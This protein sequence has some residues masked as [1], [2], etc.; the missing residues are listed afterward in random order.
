MTGRGDA[1]DFR[2]RLL[3]AC[4]YYDAPENYPARAK[5]LPLAKY[6]GAPAEALLACLKAGP[7]VGVAPGPQPIAYRLPG[8]ARSATN[9]A[10]SRR[11]PPA[12]ALART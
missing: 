4:A 7:S 9:S 2:A 12:S 10:G 6:A 11:K 1:G 5:T 8:W 3:R